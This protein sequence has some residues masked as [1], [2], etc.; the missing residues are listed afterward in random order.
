MKSKIYLEI[1]NDIAKNTGLGS[2]IY[3][4]YHWFPHLN[5]Y[6]ISRLWQKFSQSFSIINFWLSL[7][8]ENKESMEKFLDDVV[9]QKIREQKLKRIV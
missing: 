1:L 5:Q 8:S 4:F 9:T 3:D 2:G 7:D 6:E